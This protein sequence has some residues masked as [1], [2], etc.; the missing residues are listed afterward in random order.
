MTYMN[1]PATTRA[2]V[3]LYNTPEDVDALAMSL[4]KII[5]SERSSVITKPAP[6]V[7]LKYPAATAKSIESAADELAETFEFLGDREARTQYIMEMGE[8]IPS[9]P[10]ALKTETTRV[11]GCMSV[12]HLYGH[13]QDSK[14]E[15]I[16]DSDAHLVRGLIAMLEKLFSGQDAKQVAAFDV[17]AFLRRIELDQFITTQRRNGLA[18]M[19]AK[20]RKLATA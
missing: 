3:A 11:Q 12:V 10:D 2:S 13:V 8:K 14:L 4:R 19:I 9:M 6:A 16:A 18:G 7:E 20:I 1:V 5:A 17:E 15:F